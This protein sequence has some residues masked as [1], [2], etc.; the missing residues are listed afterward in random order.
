M[1]LQHATLEIFMKIFAVLILSSLSVSTFAST[2]SK[3][4]V[5]TVLSGEASVC[6]QEVGQ[7]PEIEASCALG[8]IDECVEILSIPN[9]ANHTLCVALS[10]AASVCND[11][12]DEAPEAQAGCALSF[13]A[14]C[15]KYNQR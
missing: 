2:H 8:L 6:S 7:G 15:D 1:L 13:I 4:V 10:G 14:A 3:Q 12:A 9:Q 5:C 11:Q